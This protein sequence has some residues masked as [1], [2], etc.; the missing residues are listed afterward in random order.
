MTVKFIAEVSSNH[1]QDLERCLQ[2]VEQSAAIGADAVKFQLFKIEELFAPEIIA[3]SGKHSERKN[4][5]LPVAFLPDIAGACREYKL[6]L[7]CTPFYLRAVEELY[8]FVD[9]YK[10]ASY[11]LLWDELL[12]ECAKTGKPVMLSTGMATL[13][14]IEHAVSTLRSAGCKK[15][16]LFHCVSGYPAPLEECN[17]SAIETLRNK[18]DCPTGWSDH[19]VS[20]AVL[21]RVVHRWNA[22]AVEFHLDIDKQGAEYETGHCWIPGEIAPV[23]KT[24]REGQRADGNGQKAPVPSELPDRDWRADPSDG[25]R[26]FK[27]IRKTWRPD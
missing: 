6:E 13:N 11:E 9:S 14:E 25:L 24:I 4:W 21:Y 8:P 12:K 2:F 15:L 18:F 5:E 27:K 16:T 1:N 23:I 3:Q 7:S 20:P 26:P 10:I 17:L 19:S 22:A